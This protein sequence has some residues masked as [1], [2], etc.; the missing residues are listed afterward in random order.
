MDDRAA[1]LVLLA[2]ATL[3]WE[4]LWPRLWPGLGV[5]ALFVAVALA[6]LLP[7]LP[8]WLHA[9]VLAVFFGA[10]VAALRHLWPALMPVG[11]GE[12]RHRLERD[13]GLEHRPLAALADRLGAGADDPVA[14]A[15]WAIHRRRMAAAIR[16]LR[17]HPPAPG[18]PARDPLALRAVPLLLLAAGLIAGGHDAVNRLRRA[19]E[20]GVGAPPL[21]AVLDLWITPPAYTGRAPLF[22]GT[23]GHPDGP[24]AVPTGSVLL[25]QVSGGHA[26]PRLSIAGRA[27]D[28][29]AV[30]G[31]SFR[32]ETT[33]EGAGETRLVVEQD[34]HELATW[35]TTL[36]PDRPPT[37]EFA[38]APAAAPGARLRLD[39][40]AAD[41]YGVTALKAVV[42]RDDPETAPAEAAV[43][44]PLAQA[45]APQVRGSSFHDLAAH[46]WAGLPVRIRLIAADA[47]NQTGESEEIALLLPERTFN[48]PVARAVAEQRKRLARDPRTR[49]EVAAALD[50]ILLQPMHFHD[51]T[52]IFLALRVAAQRLRRDERAAAVPQVL[53]ILW[54]VALRI[55]EGEAALAERDLLAAERRLAEAL[56][57]DAPGA[58]IERLADELRAALDKYL[59]A[60]R[61]QL[62][63]QGDEPME[64]PPSAEVLAADDLQQ[65]LER[66]RELARLGMRD[67]ARQA[68]EEMRRMLD[69]LR[70]AARAGPMNRQAAEA[71]R[72]MDGLRDLARRQQ[73]LMDRT[74]QANQSTRLPGQETRRPGA[75]PPAAFAGQTGEQE[76]LRRRLGRLMQELSEMTGEIPD[77]LGEA[78][79]AMREAGRALSGGDGEAA[80]ARQG[81]VLE[82]LRSGMEGAGEALARRMGGGIGL[83]GGGQPGVGRDPLGRTE[84][85]GGGAISDGNVRVPDQRELKRA[86][87]IQDELRRRAGQPGR[88]DQERQYID[89]LL[90][91]F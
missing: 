44:L 27:A 55:E 60:L 11:D 6:D 84:G 41:D 29:P 24:L 19:F 74:F 1:R 77:A 58:E 48:H 40:L 20:P 71:R 57:S 67:A 88:P 22:A 12:A 50:R 83:S 59:A 49:P 4:R 16:R 8:A 10:L 7:L 25:A 64:P 54:S 5:V 42:R 62:L 39:Y 37:V 52:V 33:I 31:N 72:L 38:Q 85:V 15:L 86:R 9:A 18:M 81:E 66:A 53:D 75:E 70:E 43:E 82:R 51:D 89:R 23:T 13:S 21:P 91:R 14:A 36:I 61:D 2:R 46:P 3:F 65:M 35:P 56:R 90:R 47:R 73:E 26:A 28:F 79:R 80:L 69:D 30:G 63:K 45:A 17:L 68:L 78:E 76:E 32:L 87:Q 34:G